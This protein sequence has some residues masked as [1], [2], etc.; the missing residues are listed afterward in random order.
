MTQ[1]AY[2]VGETRHGKNRKPKTIY[3]QEDRAV[4]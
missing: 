1:Q 2:L 3:G 4:I